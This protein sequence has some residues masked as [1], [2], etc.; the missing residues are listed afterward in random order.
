MMTEEEYNER[1]K[2]VEKVSVSFLE[3]LL[4]RLSNQEKDDRKGSQTN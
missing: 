1:E 4:D 2:M 3:Q